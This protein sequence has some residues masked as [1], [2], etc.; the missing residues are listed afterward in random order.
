METLTYQGIPG[1]GLT[2]WDFPQPP[3]ASIAGTG[4]W[5]AAA[6]VSV[7][8]QVGSVS[9]TFAVTPSLAM[10]SP[11]NAAPAIQAVI[12]L[13]LTSDSN[14]TYLLAALLD[15]NTTLSSGMLGVNGHFVDVTGQIPTLGLNPLVLSTLANSSQP[16]S[17]VFGAPCSVCI[18]VLPGAFALLALHLHPHDL[19]SFF[20]G[21]WN[22]LSGVVTALLAT[23][24]RLVTALVGIAWNALVAA[25]AYFDHIRQGLAHLAEV[26]VV[27]TVG[28]LKVVGAALEAALQALLAFVKAEII[29]LLTPIITPIVNAAKTFDI[30]LGAASN[31]TV[32]DIQASGSVSTTDALTWA[33]TFD[34]IAELGAAVGIAITIVLVVTTSVGL[35]ASLVVGL[36]L[37]LIPTFLQ[38]LIP[39][40]ASI[41]SLTSSSILNLEASFSNPFPKAEWEAI[42]GAVAVAAS[43]SDFFFALITAAQKGLTES[44]AA[45]LAVSIIVDLIVLPIS[46][47]TW[48]SHNGVIAIIALVLALVATFI[49]FQALKSATQSLKT[50]ATVSFILAGV[51]AAAAGGDVYLAST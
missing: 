17:G 49:A 23:A 16:D 30:T 48:A 26:A 15:N 50:Y 2:N 46:I 7:N 14:L 36:L 10:D 5:S 32:A 47:I 28:A 34:G 39:G 3:Y 12:T 31:T 8:G 33:H 19:F 18:P 20:A 11:G 6:S 51:G 4:T 38:S 41:S 40:L 24:S 1:D 35:G 43:S 22:S 25:A 13:N 27:A 45:T 37:S 42:A 44:I 21:L 29:K 9:S